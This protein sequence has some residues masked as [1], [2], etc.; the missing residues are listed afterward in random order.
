MEET[1]PEAIAGEAEQGQS[2]KAKGDKAAPMPILQKRNAGA[3][4]RVPQKQTTTQ[5]S[6]ADKNT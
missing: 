1:A 5:Y 3:D 6:R 4:L 2:A